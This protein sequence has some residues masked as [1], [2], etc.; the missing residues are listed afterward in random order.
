MLIG[1]KKMNIFKNS[2]IINNRYNNNNNNNN[3]GS[4]RYTRRRSRQVSMY[5]IDTNPYEQSY[6]Q[7]NN[8]SASYRVQEYNGGGVVIRRRVVKVVMG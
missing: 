5:M 7:C 3:N 8:E 6:K 4:I 2:F 1:I